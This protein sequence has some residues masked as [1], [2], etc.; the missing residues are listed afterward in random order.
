MEH[1]KELR[2][3]ARE[4]LESGSP[5]KKHQAQGMLMVLDY[6]FKIELAKEVLDKQGYFVDNLWQLADVQG[7][8]NCSDMIAK[9]ILSDVLENEYN[10]SNTFE[11]IDDL[12]D[13]K[14]L[15]KH[16]R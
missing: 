3:K 4:L 16:T 1:L 2:E 6:A 5:K 8:Y 7:N 11:M 13:S 15:K 9:E 14:G 12:A 10:V